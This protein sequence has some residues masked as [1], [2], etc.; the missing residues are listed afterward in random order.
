MYDLTLAAAEVKIAAPGAFNL[1]VEAFSKLETKYRD[2]LLAAD[3]SGIFVAQGRASLASQLHK[4]IEKC[5]EKKREYLN[6]Q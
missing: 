5:L 2:E 1:L 6:R 3:A 4:R